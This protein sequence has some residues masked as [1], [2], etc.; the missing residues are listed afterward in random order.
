MSQLSPNEIVNIIKNRLIPKNPGLRPHNPQNDHRAPILRR[1]HYHPAFQCHRKTLPLSS[2]MEK[3]NYNNESKA[4]K[5]LHN[6][7]VV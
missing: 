1:L 2:V 5:R 4:G 7:H 3:V 6:P